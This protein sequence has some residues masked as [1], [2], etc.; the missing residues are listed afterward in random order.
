MTIDDLKPKKFTVTIKELQLECKPLRLSHVLVISKIGEILQNPKEHNAKD[1]NQAQLDLDDVFKDL[2]PELMGVE[3]SFE[4]SITL[5]TQLMDS[6]ETDDSKFI[7]ESGV[8][9]PDLKV[10]TKTETT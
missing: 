8:N 7:N 5:I 1:I 4:D 2:I 9:H 10:K 3:L 6:T